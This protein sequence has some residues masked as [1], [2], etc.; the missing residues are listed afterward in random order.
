[1][2]FVKT[3]HSR[4]PTTCRD[5]RPTSSLTCSVLRHLRWRQCVNPILGFFEGKNP[6]SYWAFP[7]REK[8]VRTRIEIILVR[9][10]GIFARWHCF[11]RRSMA[12]LSFFFLFLNN[13]TAMV[14]CYS[15]VETQPQSNWTATVSRKS[16]YLIPLKIWPSLSFRMVVVRSTLLS[17][18]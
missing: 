3:L 6:L 10:E 16:N 11:T 12:T 2:A 18:K 17:A 14:A 7:L 1:M 5:D 13:P 15:S 9:V 4:T 8:R